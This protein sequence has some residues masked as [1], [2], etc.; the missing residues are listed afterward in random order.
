MQESMSNHAACSAA[1]P[2]EPAPRP[3]SPFQGCGKPQCPEQYCGIESNADTLTAML[4]SSAAQ[5][6]T[7]TQ[8][9]E[10]THF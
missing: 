3:A 8:V 10:H 4:I 1:K 6:G 9:Q 5:K 7:E 2:A